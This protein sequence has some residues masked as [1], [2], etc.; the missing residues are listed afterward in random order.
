MTV[1]ELKNKIDALRGDEPGAILTAKNQKIK[2]D[3]GKLRLSLVP[4][5]LVRAVAKVREY[6]LAKYGRAESWREV[7]PERYRD[8]AYRHLLAY[9]DNP[10]GRDAESG[11]KHLEHLACNIAFL[12]ELEKEE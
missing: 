2:Q 9:I 7:E 5:E 3:A 6:G 4:G 11:L 8:A 12:L 1:G 10:Q